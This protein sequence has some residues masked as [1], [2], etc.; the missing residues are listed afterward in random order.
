MVDLNEVYSLLP[1][2][3]LIDKKT[4]N[5][6]TTADIIKQ[7]LTQHEL[8]KFDAKKIAHLFD[9]GNVYETSQAIWNFLKYKVK[10]SVEPANFQS[11]KTLSRFIYDA[12]N[13]TGKNDCKHFANFTG[14]ILDALGYKFKYRFAGYSRYSKNPTHVYVVALDEN[15]NEILIDA[16]INGFDI[17][18]PFQIKIDKKPKN[19]SLYS[20]SGIDENA[21]INGIFKKAKAA[22]KKVT[23]TATSAVKKVTKPIVQAAK[24]V[25]QGALTV[26]L[27][28]PRNAFLL[29]LRFNVHGWATGLSKMSWERLKWWSDSFGGNRTDLQKAINAGAKNKRI[30]G[31]NYNDFLVPESVGAIGV[32]PVSV[33]AALASAAPIISKVS[34]LL[35]EA[36]KISDTALN[37]KSQVSKTTDAINRGNN[38]F[39]SLTGKS[40]SD[41]I[42]KKESGQTAQTSIL[43]TSDFKTPTDNEAMKVAN[44]ALNTNKPAIN[45][46]LILIGGAGLAALFLLS[47]KR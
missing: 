29:L 12:I 20:L 43:N 32:E 26:G 16:V 22:A 25:K 19:M 11:T 14:A 27:S 39:K 3:K 28:I 42:F 40:V 23:K 5:N 33:T 1:K 7:V 37:I 31:I 30:L 4:I 36:E 34:N 18:K 10:Y 6:Q 45:K 35:K 15:E 41:V 2:A 9:F 8:N 21:E 38:T 44:A 13:N 24:V 47:K 46:N 17:E